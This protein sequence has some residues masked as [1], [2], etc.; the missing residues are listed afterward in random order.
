M[1]KS[2]VNTK[3]NVCVAN[4]IADVLFGKSLAQTHEEGRG[5]GR[6]KRLRTGKRMEEGNDGER[7]WPAPPYMN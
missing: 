4:E 3:M 5:F 2:V 6:R 7:L 1:G